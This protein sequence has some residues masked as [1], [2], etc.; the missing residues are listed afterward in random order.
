MGDNLPH[1]DDLVAC[2]FCEGGDPEGCA[3]CDGAGACTQLRAEEYE[4]SIR[5]FMTGEPL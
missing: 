5:S 1:P 2:P 4:A 3:C